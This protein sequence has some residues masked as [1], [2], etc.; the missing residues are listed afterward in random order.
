M[1]F[2]ASD[3]ESEEYK[4]E[5]IWDCAV[6]VRESESGQLLGF[7]YLLSWKGYLEEGNT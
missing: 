6:Y 1:K 4:V 2:D 7:Y 5:A 3:D